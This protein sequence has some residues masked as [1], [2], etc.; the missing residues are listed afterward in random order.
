VISVGGFLGLGAKLVKIPF[1]RLEFRDS[2]GH[3]NKNVI[4]PGI[5]RQALL[6][7]QS[8]HYTSQG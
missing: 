8:Y 3:N 1:D 7:M 4:L 2:T 5:T 6:S